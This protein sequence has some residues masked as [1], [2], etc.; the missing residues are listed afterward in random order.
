MLSTDTL[1]QTF[2]LILPRIT[3]TNSRSQTVSF[4]QWHNS[5][6]IIPTVSS[7]HAIPL[8]PEVV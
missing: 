2:V 7:R 6:A 3:H 1:W 8:Q 5:A 4:T